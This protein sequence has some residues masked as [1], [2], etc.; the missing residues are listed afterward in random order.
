MLAA[1]QAA[2]G[3]AAT[4]DASEADASHSDTP[5]VPPHLYLHVPF[6]HSRC[7]YCDFFTQCDLSEER[8]TTFLQTMHAELDRWRAYAL[9]GTLETIYAGGGT[10][11][12]FMHLARLLRGVGEYLPVGRR[13]EITVETNPGVAE[14]H[15]ELLADVGVTR[16]SV[17]VQSLVEV[18]LRVLGRSHTSEQAVGTCA[19]VLDAGLD[20]S[21]DLMC[22]IPGQSLAS[23]GYTLEGAIDTGAQHVS[24]YP[25]TLEAGTPL[26]AACERGIAEVPDPDLTAGMML[27]A[28]EH[29]SA[30]GIERYEVANYAVPGRESR[31]NSA[32]WTGRSYLGLGPA[33]HSMLDAE[34]AVA[35]GLLSD[36]DASRGVARVRV[37]NPPELA[38]W[39]DPGA[40]E[41]EL[42]DAAEA[43]REDAMLG[44]RLVSGIG[45]DL[46]ERADV[47]RV[48]ASLAADGLVA[49]VGGRWRTTPRGWLLGNE[50]FARVWNADPA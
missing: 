47:V 9:P 22:G 50:V 26:A 40:R 29:L 20:L 1:G 13:A 7:S 27:L 24:V 49:H 38:A 31:H 16:V 10:P 30:A 3:A 48:L 45:E 5:R 17:G 32:Y 44:L 41:I 33:A 15:L 23:W 25:L 37:G 21:L 6:C 11:T 42:L 14:P 18:E 34:T 12:V 36:E 8:A 2:G 28:E 46:A 19:A 39:A 4:H 35:T 43:A